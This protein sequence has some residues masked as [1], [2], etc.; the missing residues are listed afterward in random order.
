MVEWP[1]LA[2]TIAGVIVAPLMWLWA[3]RI[4]ANLLRDRERARA[5]RQGRAPL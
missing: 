4:H 2:P 5:E 1:L 3:R